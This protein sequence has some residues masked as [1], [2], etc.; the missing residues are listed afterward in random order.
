MTREENYC[1]NCGMDLNGM[2][3]AQMREMD[4]RDRLCPACKQMLA[5]QI[6]AG[7][8]DDALISEVEE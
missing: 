8:D 7:A 5:E 3:V 4:S 1:G 6:A 2:T